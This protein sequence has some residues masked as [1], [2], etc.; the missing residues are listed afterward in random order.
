MEEGKL[1]LGPP[2]FKNIAILGTAGSSMG[3][4]PFKDPAWAIWACSPGA[5]S[6]CAQNRSDVWFEVHR[7]QPT[8]PGKFGAPGTKPWFSPEFHTFLSQHKGPVFMAA[9]DQTIPQSTRIPFEMLREKYGPYVWQSTM[10][11]MLALAIEELA[12]RAAAGEQVSIGLW[13]VDMSAAEEWAYQ[14]PACQHFLG[15]AMSLG[16]NVALP[17]ESDLMRP[18]TMYG[19][20]ELNPRHIRLTAMLAEAKAHKAQCDAQIANGQHVAA[21]TSG[22]ISMLEYLL[23]S[24]TDD[25]EVDL[26][27][28]ISFAGQ[29]KQPVGSLT[30]ADGATGAEVLTLP[31]AEGAA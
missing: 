22:R 6:I 5:Y 3:L 14:R 2:G 12:P 17:E 30:A 7:W 31:K 9:V 8:P 24:W 21:V 10:S 18:P 29:F 15:L 20:G 26:R 13:G 19:I 27:Q 25:V 4:A 16:I 1:Q 23:A 28:A 11:Y